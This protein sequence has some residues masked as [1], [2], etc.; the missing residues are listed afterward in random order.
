MK[1]VLPAKGS[2]IEPGVG[3]GAGAGAGASAGAGAGVGG[4]CAKSNDDVFTSQGSDPIPPPSLLWKLSN[5]LLS[6]LFC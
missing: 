3:A 1:A 5:G 2:I 6:M 4:G